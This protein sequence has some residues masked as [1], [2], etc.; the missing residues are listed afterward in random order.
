[1]TTRRSSKMLHGLT[2]IDPLKVPM[3]DPE[4]LA[5][6]SRA[7]PDD[8]IGIPEFGTRFVRNMLVETKPASFGDLVRISGLSRHRRVGKQRPGL[9]KNSVAKFKEVIAT[10]KTSSYTSCKMGMESALAFAIAER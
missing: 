6:F 4:T 7:N 9:I 5:L 3:D 2:G 1:M 8:A 10:R